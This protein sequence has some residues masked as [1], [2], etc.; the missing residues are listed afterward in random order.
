MTQGISLLLPDSLGRLAPTLQLT[1][2]NLRVKGWLGILPSLFG[3]PAL[4]LALNFYTRQ[5]FPVPDK[6]GPKKHFNVSQRSPARYLRSNA[7]T[8][9]VFPNV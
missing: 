2:H 5:Y 9:P 4:D 7:V 3:G 6:S 8:S 1:V